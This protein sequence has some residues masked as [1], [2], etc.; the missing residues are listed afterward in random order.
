MAA[1]D[2]LIDATFVVVADRI[3]DPGNAG[4]ILRSAEA[5]GA[6]AVI[7][8]H[9]SVDVFNP[10]VVRACAGALFEVPVVIDVSIDDVLRSLTAPSGRCARSERR[11]MHPNR[12]PPATALSAGTPMSTSPARR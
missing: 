7:L 6:D 8:T 12:P 4:T 5:A 1:L 2:T 10:K 3:S 9:G 11:H